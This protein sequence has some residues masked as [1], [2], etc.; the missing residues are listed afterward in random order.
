MTKLSRIEIDV[1]EMDMSRWNW[2]EIQLQ[3]I[4]IFSEQPLVIVNVY[5]CNVKVDAQKWVSIRVSSLHMKAISFF[6][7]I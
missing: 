6:A 3:V 4:H 2:A 7:V 5:A 1:S